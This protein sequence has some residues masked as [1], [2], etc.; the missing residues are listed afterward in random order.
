MW[1]RFAGSFVR[2]ANYRIYEEFF[3]V[4]FGS[5]VVISFGRSADH[6]TVLLNIVVCHKDCIENAKLRSSVQ[7]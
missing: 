7:I 3:F 5:F 6:N 1:R 4:P 2:V